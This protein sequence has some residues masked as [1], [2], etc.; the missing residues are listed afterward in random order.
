MSELPTPER[1][2]RSSASCQNRL[3][4]NA[5]APV[6]IM[7]EPSAPLLP[8]EGWP[9]AGV[10]G[11]AGVHRKSEPPASAGGQRKSEPPA[12]AGGQHCRSPQSVRAFSTSQIRA[13]VVGGQ[14]LSVPPA[15]PG[16]LVSTACVSGRSAL[17][18]PARSKGV[19]VRA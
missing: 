6:R 7:S 13:C 8:E 15:S 3:R 19:R 10:E 17:Q 4:R 14:A 16:G 12:S 18:K 2:T 11:A 1:R 5:D 9:K